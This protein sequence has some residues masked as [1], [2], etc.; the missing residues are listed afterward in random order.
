MFLQMS[1][2]YIRQGEQ[3][4]TTAQTRAK[5]AELKTLTAAL[6]AQWAEEQGTMQRWLLGWSQPLTADPSSGAHEGHGDLHSLRPSDIAELQA[7][8]DNFDGT[9]EA[10]LLGHLHNC[11]EVSRMESTGGQYP[12]AK[13]LAEQMA[14][15]RQGQVQRLLKLQTGSTMGA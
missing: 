15:T 1:L 14:A 4:L 12:P 7:T 2:E 5:N 11:V 3:V 13:A 6:Q 9:A 10:L 8:K